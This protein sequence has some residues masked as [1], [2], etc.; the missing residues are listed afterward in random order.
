MPV[1]DNAIYHLAGALDRLGE[2]RLSAEDQRGDP[3]V[4]PRD[5]EDRERR[6][7][8]AD[9]AKTAEGDRDAMQRVA[10]RDHR[11]ERDPAHDLR[12]H[13]ARRRPRQERAAAARRRQRQLPRAAGGDSAEQVTATLK[14]VIADDQVNITIDG[15]VQAGPPSRRCATIS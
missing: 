9:L 10:A 2:V 14:Q 5:G 3:R 13:P 6:R 8:S 15:D 1:A 12:R 11:L 4:L 7:F